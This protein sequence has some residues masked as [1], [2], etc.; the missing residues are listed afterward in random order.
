MLAWRNKPDGQSKRYNDPRHATK[1]KGRANEMT[2]QTTGQ[3][4]PGPWKVRYEKSR[5]R[6]VLSGTHD[7]I[8][9]FGCFKGY[10]VDGVTGE[11]EDAANAAFICRACNN[12]DEL[13]HYLWFL[14]NAAES[15]PAMAIYKAHIEKARAAL[16]AATKEN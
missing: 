2:N 6:F 8:G 11:G 7:N 10:E 3:R 15:E 16:T 14:T 4:T 9:D 1:T 5:D 13:L 12:F